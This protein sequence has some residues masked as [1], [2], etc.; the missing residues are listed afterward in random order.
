[1]RYRLL[2]QGLLVVGVGAAVLGCETQKKLAVRDD[3]DEAIAAASARVEALEGE[4]KDD[5][6]ASKVA[7][8][9]FKNNRLPGG[10]SD[11]ANEIE[12]SLGVGP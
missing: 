8:G 4:D 12:R 2:R 6:R 7:K 1:M 5:L 9:F 10:W 3:P 11:Q